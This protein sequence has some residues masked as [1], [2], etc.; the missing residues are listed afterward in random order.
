MKNFVFS[1]FILK[2]FYTFL[3][4]RVVFAVLYNSSIVCTFIFMF[5]LRLFAGIR[6]LQYRRN[7][8]SRVRGTRG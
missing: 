5:I 2:F 7:G 1:T 4:G 8:T 3:R 6:Y